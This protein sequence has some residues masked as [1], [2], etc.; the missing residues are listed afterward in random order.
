MNE[1]RRTA[2]GVMGLEWIGLAKPHGTAGL[3]TTR[4][5]PVD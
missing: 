3:K 1:N 4:R 5:V 2:G